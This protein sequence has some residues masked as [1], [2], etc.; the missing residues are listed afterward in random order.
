[1]PGPALH[2]PPDTNRLQPQE[3]QRHG[4]RFHGFR[5]AAL[6]SRA[7]RGSVAGNAQS[8]FALTKLLSLSAF[9]GDAKASAIRP[10]PPPG[11]NLREI[12]IFLQGHAG[13][14]RP[15]FDPATGSIARSRPPRPPFLYRRRTRSRLRQQ[16]CM[17]V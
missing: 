4:G 3:P 12:A 10:G 14:Q 15:L 16:R 2:L 7:V 17:H 1:M 9:A 8:E 5:S 11:G 13:G 6:Q